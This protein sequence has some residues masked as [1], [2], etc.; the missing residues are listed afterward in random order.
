MNIV[1]CTR[2][3][4]IEKKK[5]SYAPDHYKVINKLSKKNCGRNVEV[6]ARLV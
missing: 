2:K 4:L 6:K 5:L 3:D 1:K